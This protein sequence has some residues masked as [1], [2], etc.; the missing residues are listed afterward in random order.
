MTEL[1]GL[2]PLPAAK[3]TSTFDPLLPSRSRKADVPEFR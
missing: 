1:D 2:Q 3:R